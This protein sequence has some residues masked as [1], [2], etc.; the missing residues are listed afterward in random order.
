MT[1]KTQ[2]I[3]LFEVHTNQFL[4]NLY[5]KML[6]LERK[7]VKINDLSSYFKKLKKKST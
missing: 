2:H 6:V 1:M 5:T 7:M 3:K 4:E